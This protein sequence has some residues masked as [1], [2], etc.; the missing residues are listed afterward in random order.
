MTL[1]APV[2]PGTTTRTGKPWSRGNGLRRR[3]TQCLGLEGTGPWVVIP[4]S[5][6]LLYQYSNAPAVHLVGK[7]DIIAAGHSFVDRNGGPIAGAADVT[8]QPLE[9]DVLDVT[10][11]VLSKTSVSQ[12]ITQASPTELCCTDGSCR[13]LKRWDSSCAYK[14]SSGEWTMTVHPMLVRHKLISS[15]GCQTAYLQ[16][17]PAPSLP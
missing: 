17:I 6:R 8:V 2:V 9:L 5:G 7:N 10:D 3:C 1:R 4:V 11:S 13:A 16:P 12:H 15:V 14:T